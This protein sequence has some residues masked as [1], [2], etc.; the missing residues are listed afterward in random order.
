MRQ[1]RETATSF[2]EFKEITQAIQALKKGAPKNATNQ[3]SERTQASANAKAHTQE[4]TQK[5]RAQ[6][7]EN[8]NT[9]ELTHKEALKP[10]GCAQAKKGALKPTK[11]AFSERE[12]TAFS[13]KAS[14]N[15][16]QQ[17]KQGLK[18]AKEKG[19]NNEA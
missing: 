17:T 10:K 1:T 5:T 11:K 7:H 13:D 8:A 18:E 6:T 3:E 9:S 4:R 16:S 19:G 15:K 2:K 14:A 12:K